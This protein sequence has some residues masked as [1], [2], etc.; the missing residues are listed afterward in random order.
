MMPKKFSLRKNPQLYEINTAAWLF[1]LSRKSGKPVLL[2]DVPPEE[3]DELKSLGM[4]L[5]WLM[6]VWNRSQE[7]RKLNLNS[8]E[9]RAYFETVLPACSVEDIIGSCYSISSYGPDPLVG[10]W[11]DLDHARDELHKR[12]IGL[13]L[14]FVPNHTGMDHQWTSEHPEYYIQGTREDFQKEPES[15]FVVENG[16][17]RLYIA[18]G[19]DP[20]FPPWTDTAQLNYFNP[21]ARQ[22][23]IQRI[24]TIAKH[25]DGIRCDMAMLVLNDVF[26]RV[27]SW[28][29]RHP[30]YEMP[31]REFWTQAIRQVPD[32][33]F[34]AEAYWDTEWNLM[35]LGF[36]F[37]YD[38]RLFDR[39]R[40]AH[41][42]DVYLHLTAGIEYQQKLVRFIENHDEL[43]SLTAFGRG[44]VKAVATLFS[45]LPGLKLYFQGQ[46]EGKQIRMPVQI[47]QTR[48]EPVD[49]EIQAFY[50]VLMTAINEEIF[51]TGT[52][53]LK[54]VLPDCDNAFE[55]LIAYTWKLE[56][57]FRLIIV[58]L[59]QYPSCGRL[60]FQDDPPESQDYSFTDI[61]SGQNFIQSGIVMAH[62]GLSIKLAGYQAQIWKIEPESS[63]RGVQS[64][65]DNEAN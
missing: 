52:W 12:G 14:D 62:P 6:G 19:R 22:A 35:Q 42:H 28:A 9:F 36:D 45:T 61:L 47:R 25:C 54:E 56:N 34:I 38:K 18:H 13:I 1:E 3:W 39:M 21:E 60:S 4:D 53:K 20:N 8:P 27:W 26:K 10:T 49:S 51:H 43:R 29:N 57:S 24:E 11:Q 16:S 31:S 32:L 63:L 23:V 40:N 41:P 7:G 46:L 55:N 15:F 17:R 50:S 48:P 58:N 5:V 33:I 2:G 59:S 30:E 64:H 37:V 65:L 44:K